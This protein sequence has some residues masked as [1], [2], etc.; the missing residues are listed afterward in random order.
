MDSHPKNGGGVK[1]Q[2]G[3]YYEGQGLVPKIKRNVSLLIGLIKLGLKS[4]HKDD[5][6]F[7]LIPYNL[8]LQNIFYKAL[9]SKNVKLHLTMIDL[10]KARMNNYDDVLEKKVCKKSDTLIAQTQEMKDAMIQ[11]EYL[12]S[13]TKVMISHFWP[14]LTEM[15]PVRQSTFANSIAFSGALN[16]APFASKLSSLD[17]RLQ[18]TVNPT[19]RMITED[20]GLVWDGDSLETC[21]GRYGNYMRMVFPYKASLYLASNRPLIVWKE[22]G[23]ARYVEEHHLGVTVQTLHDIYDAI[24]SISDTEKKLMLENVAKYCEMIRI[25]T[26]RKDMIHKILHERNGI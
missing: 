19:F 3:N 4:F 1:Y 21:S 13:S 15:Q 14:I 25:G 23:I 11:M 2:V 5:N 26:E 10:T 18:F 22:C 8:P 7:V 9:L 20:W 17:E 6:L 24:T 12:G 16:K